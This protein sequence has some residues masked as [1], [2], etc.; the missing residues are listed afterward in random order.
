LQALPT[1]ILFKDGKVID[2]IEGLLDE[3][4]LYDRVTYML[5]GRSAAA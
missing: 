2:R 3:Q 5:V 1:L 4:Q